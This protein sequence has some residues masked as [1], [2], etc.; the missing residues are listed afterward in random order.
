MLAAMPL[1][2]SIIDVIIM[3]KIKYD[4]VHGKC[5]SDAED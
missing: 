3:V 5:Q 1:K 4:W 2:S